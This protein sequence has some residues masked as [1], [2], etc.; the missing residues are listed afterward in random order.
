MNFFAKQEQAKKSTRWLVIIYGIATLAIVAGVT[1][2]TAAALMMNS[3]QGATLA[4]YYANLVLA[5][6]ITLA[7]ILGASLYKIAR[8]S[9]GGGWVALE[10]GGTMIRPEEQEPLRRRLRNVVEEMSIASGVPV[11]EIYVL[12]GEDT[13]NAFASGFSSKDAAITVTRGALEKLDRDELQGVIAHEFSHIL[14]G[15]MRLNIRLMGVLFGILAL[16]LIGR[17]IMRG[18]MYST[19][20]RSNKNGAAFAIMLLGMGLIILG[21]IGVFFARLIKAAVSRQREFLA[22]ASA[23]QFTRQ[24]AGLAGALKKIGN[25][26]NRSYMRAPKTEEISHMLFSTGSRSIMSLFATHPP[27]VDRIRALE[28]SFN[29]DEFGQMLPPQMPPQEVSD[30]SGVQGFAPGSTG[31]PRAD[32]VDSVGHP[33]AEHVAYAMALRKSLPTNLYD[34]A[35]SSE[36]SILLCLAIILHADGKHREYQLNFLQD[37]LGAARAKLVRDFSQQILDL[38]AH[39]RLP[40]LAIALPAIRQRPPAEISFLLKNARKLI[41]ADNHVDLGE[42]CTFRVLQSQLQP[43]SDMPVKPKHH[44]KVEQRTA[45][46]NIIGAVSVHGTESP[47]GRRNAFLAGMKHLQLPSDGSTYS[48]DKPE[49]ITQLDASLDALID[50][51]SDAKQNLLEALNATILRDDQV[52]IEEHELMR[53]ICA[54]INCPL[55]PYIDQVNNDQ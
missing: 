19:S 41:E 26:G 28:P 50:L 27:L 49:S 46:I 45:M 48:V 33:Q 6:V 51:G 24:T 18:G 21:A 11:P 47:E 17:L 8:L 12:E 15:D 10:M 55:P 34:A 35:H 53:A 22:D 42:F 52:S 25:Y 1:L 31:K 36:Q 29:E 20:S 14:N 54:T 44:S 5:A 4:D 40:L 3:Q 30:S 32:I 9:S 7:F 16:G 37:K 23:V 43:L 38:G 39:C 2:L 13:I